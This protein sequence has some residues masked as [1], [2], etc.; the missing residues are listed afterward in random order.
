MSSDNHNTE[1]FNQKPGQPYAKPAPEYGPDAQ[2]LII[3]AEF[4]DR[5]R[6]PE[7]TAS[8][9]GGREFKVVRGFYGDCPSCKA[10]RAKIVEL[11]EPVNLPANNLSFQ[12]GPLHCSECTACK[13]YSIYRGLYSGTTWEPTGEE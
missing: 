1:W 2:M 5:I 10:E 6:F 11:E 4:P 8:P 3:G 9:W 7:E 13:Q 12:M